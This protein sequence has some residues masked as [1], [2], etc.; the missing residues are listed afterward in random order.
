MVAD[1]LFYS[2]CAFFLSLGILRFYRV[3][4]PLS[5]LCAVLIALAAGGFVFLLLYRSRR[6]RY[7]N[8]KERESR[9]ALLLHLALEKPENVLRQLLAAYLADKKEARLQEDALL[10]D[11][12]QTVPLFT[13][14][15]VGADEIALLLRRFG[16]EP[17]T[18]LCN[19]LMPEAE[20][21]LASFGVA[22]VQ[23]DGVYALFARTDTLPSPLICGE[24]LRKTVKQKLRRTFSK[25]NARPFFVS[26][27][28]LLVMSLFTFFP[29]YY[30]ISGGILLLCAVTVRLFGYA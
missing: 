10:V 21:L 29:L 25:S 2:A 6:K 23:G 7:L 20:K 4:L 30:V 3:P 8:K 19:A 28:L 9:E 27:I 14:E 17:F 24:I 1:L 15:P 18:V 13:M 26:G 22:S 16:K 11:G 5:L 12:V